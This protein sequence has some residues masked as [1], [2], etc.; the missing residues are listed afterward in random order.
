MVV[1]WKPTQVSHGPTDLSELF[2]GIMGYKRLPG[3]PFGCWWDA[4]F[5]SVRETRW[6]DG[7]LL[8]GWPPGLIVAAGRS[9]PSG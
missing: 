2:F 8:P 1:L 5:P 9:K 3:V 6:V 7:V 4:A